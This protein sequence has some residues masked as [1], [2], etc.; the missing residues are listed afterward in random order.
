[1]Q[2]NYQMVL[3]DKLLFSNICL[4]PHPSPGTAWAQ[5]QPSTTKDGASSNGCEPGNR[6]LFNNSG[7]F[8]RGRAGM[9]AFEGSPA[10]FEAGGLLDEQQHE[11]DQTANLFV[12]ETHP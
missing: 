2:N 5:G 11:Q 7:I 3:T 9:R 12:A 8:R 10:P 1:M 6:M 4:T